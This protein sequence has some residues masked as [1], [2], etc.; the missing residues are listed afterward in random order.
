MAECNSDLAAQAVALLK[1]KDLKLCFAESL[2]GGM[3]SSGI[4]DVPGASAVFNGSVVSYVNEVKTGV[5][6]VSPEVIS[7]KTEVSYECAEQMASGAAK[8]LSADIA[9][10]VTGIAGPGGD[11]PG[12]PVGT[13]FMGIYNRGEVSSVRLDLTGSRDEI[14]HKTAAEAYRKIIETVGA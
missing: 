13:V 1:Q 7:E 12:K 5:L 14:R 8:I 11:M 3:I 10:S 2:T 4:V 6:G 9:I